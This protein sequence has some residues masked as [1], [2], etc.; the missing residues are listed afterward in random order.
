MATSASRLWPPAGSWIRRYVPH[1]GWATSRWHL[2]TGDVVWRLPWPGPSLETV[3]GYSTGPLVQ[4]DDLNVQASEPTASCLNCLSRAAS[5][6]I[7][8]P[9]L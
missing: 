2:F 4:L 3:C 9:D 6:G 5:F 8:I 1:N 7:V